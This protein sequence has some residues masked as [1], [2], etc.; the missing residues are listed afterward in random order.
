MKQQLLEGGPTIDKRFEELGIRPADILLPGTGTDMSRWAV[1]A[2]DQF[3]SQP[4]YWEEA[5]RI[6]GDAPSALRLILPESKLNDSN[7]DKHIQAI[8]R[9][10]ADYLPGIFS[11]STRSP[12]S[13]SSAPS[14]MERCAQAWWRRWTWKSMTTPPAPD[15]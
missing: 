3:T 10:M 4:E 1:V 5:D 11:L 14:P 8:N 15:H 9:A 12:S 2:C 6:A 7:V 13:T